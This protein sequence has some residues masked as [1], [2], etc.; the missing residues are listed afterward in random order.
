ML[1]STKHTTIEMF[2]LQKALSPKNCFVRKHKK[3]FVSAL[4]SGR[5]AKVDTHANRGPSH[6]KF[7]L[8][9]DLK[10]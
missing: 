3:L 9:P 6:R 1:A 5:V 8:L 7:F 10:I 2:S 4:R